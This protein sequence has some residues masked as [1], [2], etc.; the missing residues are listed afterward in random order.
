[1]EMPLV[2][3]IHSAPTQC[4]ASWHSAGHPISITY[5]PT[6]SAHDAS[7]SLPSAVGAAAAPFFP[8]RARAASCPR[9]GAETIRAPTTGPTAAVAVGARAVAAVGPP[10]R[11]RQPIFLDALQNMCT[12]GAWATNDQRRR[13]AR[14]LTPDDDATQNW[15]SDISADL[16]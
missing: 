14:D 11:N 12:L 15:K 1:M 9:V 6:T 16:V 4:A 7:A 13:Q 8:A 5:C 10:Y 2:G 3:W